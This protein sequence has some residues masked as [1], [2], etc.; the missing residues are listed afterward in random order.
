MSEYDEYDEDGGEYGGEYEDEYGED[1]S[2]F[3]AEKGEFER[4]GAEDFDIK[5]PKDNFNLK[6]K[7]NFDAFQCT[8]ED[9]HKITDVISKFKL[10]Y[11][12]SNYNAYGLV[13]GYM[14][15][16]NGLKKFDKTYAQYKDV[17]DGNASKMDILRY[18]RLWQIYLDKELDE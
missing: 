17:S 15:F 7:N 9:K 10:E 12:Y 3:Q 8:R 1:G 2:R 13:F 11:E 18:A 5:N 6:I 14:I 16:K 4:T